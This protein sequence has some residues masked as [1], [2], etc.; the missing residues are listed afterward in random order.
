[1]SAQEQTAPNGWRV[2]HGTGSA[3]ADPPALPAPPPW[4]RFRGGPPRPVP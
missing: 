1:M 4:R 3:P 2:F